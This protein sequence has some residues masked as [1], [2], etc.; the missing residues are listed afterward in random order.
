MIKIKTHNMFYK[1]EAESYVTADQLV[2]IKSDGKYLGLT[3]EMDAG[4]D[5]A[6]L[7][8]PAIAISKLQ[9]LEAKHKDKVF[10]LEKNSYTQYDTSSQHCETLTGRVEKWLDGQLKNKVA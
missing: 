10:I 9:Y 4:I 7:M 5:E 3:D 8:H 6:Q 2:K 1:I